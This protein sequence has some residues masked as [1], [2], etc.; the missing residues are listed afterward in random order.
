MKESKRAL[1]RFH[2][3]RIKRKRK[4]HFISNTPEGISFSQRRLHSFLET[5]TT[6]SCWM[7]GNPRKYFN[8]KTKQELI[9][10]DQWKL[11]MLSL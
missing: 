5:P 11:A 8:E 10:R 2:Q 1:R 9:S 4:K 6:C 7:C 3:E